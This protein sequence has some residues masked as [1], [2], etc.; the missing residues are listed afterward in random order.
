MKTP[1][2]RNRDGA[3]NRIKFQTQHEIDLANGVPSYEYSQPSRINYRKKV[4][5]EAAKMKVIKEQETKEA[6]K[7]KAEADKLAEEKRIELKNK[8]VFD[9]IDI[10]D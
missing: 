2:Q 8:T 10:D 5:K 9:I 1:S 7:L 4:G 3:A 6:K